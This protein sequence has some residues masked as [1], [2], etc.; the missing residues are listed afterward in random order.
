ML[1]IEKDK[2]VKVFSDQKS[3]VSEMKFSGLSSISCAIKRGSLSRGHYFVMWDDCD[4]KLKDDYLQNNVLPDKRSTVKS[5]KINQLH[6]ITKEVI[7]TFV[8]IDDVIKEFK[9]SRGTLKNAYTY[10][11]I[12]KGYRWVLV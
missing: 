12:C 2:I 11:I 9:V 6:P 1:N 7:K 5:K 10:D 4:Q 3:V 8:S